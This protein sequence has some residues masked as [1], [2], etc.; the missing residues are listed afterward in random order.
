MSEVLNKV[1]TT[2]EM[3]PGPSDFTHLHNHTLFSILDGV[4]APEAYFKGC[5]DRKWSSFAIT[6]HGVM[7]SIPDAYL[8]AKQFGIKYIVGNEV[9]YNDYDKI[10]S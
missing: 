3:Y 5:V 7:N 4:A 8:A 10:Q 2:E 1:L 9:Y 6:E